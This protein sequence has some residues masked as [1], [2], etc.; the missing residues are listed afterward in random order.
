[1]DTIPSIGS[2]PA[3]TIPGSTHFSN[4]YAGYPTNHAGFEAYP[5]PPSSMFNNTGP[6]S[7]ATYT[8]SNSPEELTVHP[9]SVPPTALYPRAYHAAIGMPVP[10]YHAPPNV[11]RWTNEV[12][13]AGGSRW[14]GGFEAA[15]GSTSQSSGY[16][17]QLYQRGQW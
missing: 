11:E 8:Y 13:P 5:V 7:Q 9:I 10:S 1:M 6:M 15:T 14:S 16:D 12:L 4:S 2:I 17:P 3:A